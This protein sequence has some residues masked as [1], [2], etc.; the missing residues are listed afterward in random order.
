MLHCSII[1]LLNIS[2]ESTFVKVREQD[3][4][5]SSEPIYLEIQFDVTQINKYRFANATDMCSG[6][7]LSDALFWQC[8]LTTSNEKR[9]NVKHTIIVCL[10][11][12][13]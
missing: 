5:F 11:H 13:L 8:F 2:R 1:N 4:D 6:N 9:K 7:L 10:L 3:R 12:N